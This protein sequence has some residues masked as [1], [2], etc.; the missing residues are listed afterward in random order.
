MIAAVL[1]DKCPKG[2][3]E[4]AFSKVVTKSLTQNPTVDN[5]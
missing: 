3:N 4:L 5:Q 1:E 2:S